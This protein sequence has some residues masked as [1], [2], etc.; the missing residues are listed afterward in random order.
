MET[1]NDF[2]WKT[3]II[4]GFQSFLICVICLIKSTGLLHMSIVKYVFILIGVAPEGYDPIGKPDT[5]VG[6]QLRQGDAS[7]VE[8][9]V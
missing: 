3:I 9:S 1:W 8:V 4:S 5:I 6:R 2:N 7:F